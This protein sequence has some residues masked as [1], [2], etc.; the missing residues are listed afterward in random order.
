MV[1]MKTIKINLKRGS[2]TLEILLAFTILILCMSAVI[3]VSFSNQSLAVDS[4][5]NNEAISKASKM[6]EDARAMSRQNYFGVVSI[7]SV[8][9]V[10]G[11]SYTKLLNVSDLTQCKKQATSTVSWTNSGRPQKIE[12]TSFFTDIA[13]ALSLGGDCATNPPEG[14]WK[15]PDSL[16]SRE[17]KKDLSLGDNP[18]VNSDA[19]TPATDVDVLN[20]MIYMTA[21]SNKDDFFVLDG[22]N[23]LN[24]VIPPIVGSGDISIGLNAVDSAYDSVSGKYYAYVAN[25][26]TTSTESSDEFIVIDVSAPST[27]SPVK[28]TGFPHKS[29]HTYFGKLAYDTGAN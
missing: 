23:M 27:P 6:L 22:T 15:N 17:L 29:R 4:Q 24:S 12:L 7:A 11:L 1:N 3:L 25:A 26:S 2:I 28:T 5:T 20:K 18:L 14:G 19:G 13:G 21:I 10:G 9:N 16:V 8:E